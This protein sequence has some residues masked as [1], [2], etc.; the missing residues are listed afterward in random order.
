MICVYIN[1]L[2]LL[3]QLNTCC[4]AASTKHH[5]IRA[6]VSISTEKSSEA[7]RSSAQAE[8]CLLLLDSLWGVLR[9][10]GRGLVDVFCARLSM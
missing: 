2:W 10:R 3:N 9:G 7:E 1:S 4:N 8:A 5:Q 6:E